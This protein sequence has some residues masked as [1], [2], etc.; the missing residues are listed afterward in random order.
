[1]SATTISPD[2]MAGTV[3]V[4]SIDTGDQNRDAHLLSPEFFDAERHPQISFR[5]EAAGLTA[6]GALSLTG[7]ITMKGVSKPIELTGSIAEN[8]Q[9]PWGKER[10]GFEASAPVDR[11][12][13]GLT[14]NQTLPNGALL[15]ANQVRL[16]I[17]VSA[18]REG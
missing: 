13:F 5:S 15:L 12:D 11:R 17:S 18:V 14:W 3:E 16:V 4:S 7:E 10:I 2:R 8:G 6:D 9:D 1:M